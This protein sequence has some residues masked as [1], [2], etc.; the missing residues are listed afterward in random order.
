MADGMCVDEGQ[1]WAR[2][3]RRIQGCK[4]LYGRPWAMY[5]LQY[6]VHGWVRPITSGQ[7]D[8]RH[9]GAVGWVGNMNPALT[10]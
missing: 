7:N 6:A 8:P 1:V 2:K 10:R 4:Y 3:N 5:I 9:L